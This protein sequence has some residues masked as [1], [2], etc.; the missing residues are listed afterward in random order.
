MT[1]LK[2]ALRYCL[3]LSACLMAATALAQTVDHAYTDLDL[4]ANCQWADA[5]DD[6]AAM[7]GTAVCT[8][9][10]DYP[11]H[12]G[13]GDLRMFVAYGPAA[14]PFQFWH[15]FLQFNHVNNVVEWRLQD[16][17]PFAAILRYFVDNQT[18][19][20]GIPEGQILVIS[21]V[22]DPAAPPGERNSCVVAYVD[23]LA[24]PQANALA[25]EV[26]DTLAPGFVC[27]EDEPR[28]HGERGET[29][30]GTG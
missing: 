14:E 2:F 11:V 28:Y 29:A 5:S 7:G 25:R 24:N 16:G 1:Q 21:T 19:D 6:E 18:P 13:E 15:S 30:G 4:Q 9:Y 22:A 12:V 10:E 17:K 23:A 8:G 3:S 26:A 27:G 20:T